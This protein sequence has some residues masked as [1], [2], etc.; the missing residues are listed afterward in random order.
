MKIYVTRMIPE[1]A[2]A[3]LKAQGYE[4]AVSGKD[5]VLSKEELIAELKKAPYDAVLSLLTD[6][7]D[8]DVFDAVPSAKI[9]ANFAVGYNNI[10]TEA[11]TARGVTITNTPEVLT[12]TV[13]EH[14]FALMMGIA[15]RVVEGDAY[16]R[17]GKFK[18]WEPM[19]LLGTDLSGK[20]LGILGAGR[21][22]SR[23]AHHGARGFG[24]KVVYHDVK[25][26]PTL[27]AEY[28]ARY[29]A[30]PEEVLKE[31]DFVSIH[32]PLLP[33]TTHLINAERLKTM[34]KT[35]YLVNTS[36]GPVIDEAALVAAL[37]EGWIAGAA[38]DVFEHEPD[39]APGLKELPNVILTPHIASA[40]LETR[41]EMANLA[42]KNI[43][44]F[45][46]GREAPNKIAI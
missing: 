32:V 20:T 14:A 27:G 26:N 15:H 33:A 4:V 12:N 40:T 5:G 13:A 22:G 44:E 29:A 9:F 39:L 19:L 18:S 1:P 17:A 30:T 16:T 7:I 37:R 24:M 8:A 11:A 38:L 31:A 25:E 36:R 41:M 43:I 34:K 28:G 46:E 21:I 10:D 35:A 45:L 2:I 3:M 42:A 23:V 6:K